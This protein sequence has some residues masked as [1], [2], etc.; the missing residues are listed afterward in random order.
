M[1]VHKL[2]KSKV[3]KNKPKKSSNSSHSITGTRPKIKLKIQ[4]LKKKI[5]LCYHR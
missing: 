2:P 4:Y 5:L 3:T 1:R